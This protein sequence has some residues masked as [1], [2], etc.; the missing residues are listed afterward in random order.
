MT[1]LRGPTLVGRGD[2][3]LR[4]KRRRSARPTTSTR[5]GRSPS[6]HAAAQPRRP[7]R[8]WRDL[9]AFARPLGRQ[10]RGVAA[11]RNV[12]DDWRYAPVRSKGCWHDR[13]PRARPRTSPRPTASAP[14]STAW[15][16]SAEGRQGPGDRRTVNNVGGQAMTGTPP[17]PSDDAAA[18]LKRKREDNDHRDRT[19]AMSI[20]PTSRRRKSSMP[21]RSA[22]LRIAR[23]SWSP[24]GRHRQADVAG[25]RRRRQAVFVDSTRRARRRP[26][27]SRLPRPRTGRRSMPSTGGDG[28]RRQGQRRAGPPRNIPPELLRRLRPRSRWPQYRS[29]LPQ[30]GIAM[31]DRP[32]RDTGGCQCGAVRYSLRAARLGSRIC[33]CRMC[34][35]AFGGFFGPLVRTGRRA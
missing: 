23:R 27:P 6:S 9:L 3:S 13:P 10:F 1:L 5:R 19:L 22:P 28:G 25:Y 8:R 4:P 16:S 11:R 14:N 12:P 34:Q 29:R 24:R 33:H 35:K 17:Q 32:R 31:S 7:Q 26:R 21:R 2:E 20:R 30:A 15:A 18:R